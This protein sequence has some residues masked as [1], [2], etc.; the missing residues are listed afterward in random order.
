MSSMGSHKL[1]ER[2]TKHVGAKLHVVALCGELV[3]GWNHD[4]RVQEQHV[5]LLFTTVRYRGCMISGKNAAE[6]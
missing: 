3:H 5:K 1:D 4:P 6:E 2:L